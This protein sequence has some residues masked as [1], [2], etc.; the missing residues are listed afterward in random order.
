LGSTEVI[1]T[2]SFGKFR[3]VA[4]VRAKNKS[5]NVTHHLQFILVGLKAPQS[6]QEAP[7]P[8]EAS[9]LSGFCS[10]RTLK[11]WNILAIL[12]DLG[13][14]CCQKMPSTIEDESKY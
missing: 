4:E 12:R 11:F 9:I 13:E 10:S 8:P 6:G 3:K 2:A 5:Q 14:K 1:T 7:L